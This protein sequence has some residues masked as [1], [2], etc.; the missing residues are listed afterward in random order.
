V[1]GR[2]ERIIPLCPHEGANQAGRRIRR[3]RV[4][5]SDDLADRIS[6]R[7][8]TFGWTRSLLCG[9]WC[10]ADSSGERKELGERDTSIWAARRLGGSAP[11]CAPMDRS[12]ASQIQSLEIL[13]NKEVRKRGVRSAFF[14]LSTLGEGFAAGRDQR[15]SVV[16]AQRRDK[17]GGRERSLGGEEVGVVVRSEWRRMTRAG[18]GAALVQWDPTTEAHDSEVELAELSLSL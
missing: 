13:Q 1:E 18:P 12:A 3:S 14:P 15:K 16:A 7:M 2:Y 11:R 10:R 6:Y 4:Q 8:L 17:P 5:R 9:K